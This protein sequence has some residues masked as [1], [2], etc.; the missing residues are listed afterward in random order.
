M[1]VGVVGQPA[2][3]AGGLAATD[4]S[5]PVMMTLPPTSTV[6]PAPV[7]PPPFVRQRSPLVAMFVTKVELSIVRQPVVAPLL[8]S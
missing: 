7:T 8:L 5:G 4:A 6:V 2:P 3:R 1:F